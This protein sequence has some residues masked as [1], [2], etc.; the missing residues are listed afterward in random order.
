MHD[1]VAPRPEPA[2]ERALRWVDSAATPLACLDLGQRLVYVND[3]AA[4]L[5][6]LGRTE[7]LGRTP[8]DL[9]PCLTGTA[10]HEA[11]QEALLTGRPVSVQQHRP[12][13]GP[14]QGTA[15]DTAQDTPP[16]TWYRIDL[17]PVPAGL[18][19]VLTDVTTE[20]SAEIRAR[21][22]RSAG[23]PVDDDRTRVLVDLLTEASA[24]LHQTLDVEDSVHRLA[25][26][27]VPRLADWC[28]VSQ[29]RPETGL[30]EDIAVVHRDPARQAAAE[31]YAD[32][33]VAALAVEAP[34]RRALAAGRPVVAGTGRRDGIADLVPQL[35][36][37]REAQ[38][39]LTVLG[40]G[41]VAVVPLLAGS[42]AVGLISLFRDAGAPLWSDAELRT[43]IDL[44]NRAGAALAN[45]RLFTEQV[46]L[47]EGLQRS[48]LTEPPEP[49]HAEIVVRYLP[50]AEAARVGGDWYDAFLQPGGTTMVVIGDVAGHDTAAAATM[51]QLRSLLRGIAVHGDAAPAEV[52]GG[53]DRAM[54]VLDVRTLAT[55]AVA[56]FEQDE[57]ESTRGVTRMR[58]SNAGHP[59]P[60]VVDPD[61]AVGL[62]ADGPAELLLGVDPQRARRESVVTLQRGSTVLLYTD[63]LVERRDTDLD[64]G[65]AR[66]A[67]TLR[68]LAGLPLDDLCDAVLDRLVHGRPDDDVAL[69]AVRLHRQDRPLPTATG[70]RRPGSGR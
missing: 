5:T 3:A 12:R 24:V 22:R 41:A 23:R 13:P 14:D 48:L 69:V 66:L 37:T 44:G 25:R 38:R 6:G 31:E 10:L 30:L 62:L 60:M 16:D 9:W 57:D 29:M 7:L 26:L 2:T 51:G 21:Q 28:I 27:V 56:R 15:P 43:A 67:D 39:R 58:W 54:A 20:V 19:V 70:R 63:G 11:C 59:P 17:Q 32:G 55:A 64:T 35:V 68:E 42:R 45:A 50:A 34:A 61:G 65:L 4:D 1:R 36:R 33:R 53:L 40:P 18:D 8:W 49:G 47:A 52:L 46:Q